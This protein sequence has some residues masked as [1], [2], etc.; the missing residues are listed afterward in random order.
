MFRSGLTP[1]I[2]QSLTSAT[3]T[4][5]S[6]R[7]SRFQDF[8]RWSWMRS[9]AQASSTSTSAPHWLLPALW[10]IPVTFRML[11]SCTMPSRSISWGITRPTELLWAS[12]CMP[13]GSSGTLKCSRLFCTGWTR[14]WAISLTRTSSQCHKPLNGWRTQRRF[15]TFP[16]LPLGRVS[17]L[18]RI[19]QSL[20]VRRLK[21]VFW[22][23]QSTNRVRTTSWSRV[24]ITVQPPTRGPT[25]SLERIQSSL[26]RSDRTFIT[27]HL[28]LILYFYHFDNKLYGI[29]Y[30]FATLPAVECLLCESRLNQWYVLR[31][32]K[33]ILNRIWHPSSSTSITCNSYEIHYWFSSNFNA[34]KDRIDLYGIDLSIAPSDCY[35]FP[36]RLKSLMH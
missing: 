30:S 19:Y 1:S 12:I 23:Q 17:A 24:L 28:L 18:R 14:L 32:G 6:V 3:E 4:C 20:T 21:L 26:S 33:T 36:H 25:I 7:R 11:S 31:L 9:T 10:L 15:Q 35:Y 2:M 29:V 22:S 13:R 5:R 16:A 8:G 34:S 27:T